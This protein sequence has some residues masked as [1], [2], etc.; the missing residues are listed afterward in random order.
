MLELVTEVHGVL[1]IN[2]PKKR[3]KLVPVAITS[4]GYTSPI[5]IPK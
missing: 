5:H 1:P 3:V 4:I 2:L